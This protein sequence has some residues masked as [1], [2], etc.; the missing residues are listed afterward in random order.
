[1]EKY[2][3]RCLGS[4]IVEEEGMKLLEVLVINDGSTDSSSKIAHEYQDKFPDTFRVID[5]ENGNYGSCINR[6]LKEATGEFIKILDADD[7]YL[8]KSLSLYLNLL[9]TTKADMVVTNWTCH[10]FGKKS[11]LHKAK[12]IVYNCVYNLKEFDFYETGNAD[13]LVMH[14]ITYK[15]ELLRRNNYYQQEG[16]SYTDTEYVFIPLKYVL[17][18]QFFNLDLYQYFI[19]RKGQTIS[20]FSY[21]SLCSFY[22]IY[23]RLIIYYK[24]IILSNDTVLTNNTRV[25]FVRIVKYIFR[26]SLMH[27]KKEEQINLRLNSIYEELKSIDKLLIRDIDRMVS[28]KILYFVII[29]KLSGLYCSNKTINKLFN[30]LKRLYNEYR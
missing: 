10:H 1:M 7:W 5:K 29:W 3:H 24:D 6:G 22:N 26:I 11:E 8:M 12:N 19:G 25:I 13:M 21:K 4:L 15:A 30:T 9:K 28:Y 16:I 20:D 2:L 14:A 23:D 17:K 27:L 18:L